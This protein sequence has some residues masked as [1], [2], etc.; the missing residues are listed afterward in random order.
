ALVL[1]VATVLL[2]VMASLP[3][4]FDTRG[5]PTVALDYL[6]E[7]D[8]LRGEARVVT[9]DYVGNLLELRDGRA[10]A[11][12]IDDRFELH[13]RAL[14]DDYD[15]LHHGDPDW[16]DVLRRHDADVVVWERETP[17]GALLLESDDWR[18]VHDDT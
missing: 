16:R 15:T 1:A 12:F 9:Q 5:Y 14:V 11:T 2:V 4:D 3:G 17:L 7:H 18:I 10:A 13:D 8:L 6:E